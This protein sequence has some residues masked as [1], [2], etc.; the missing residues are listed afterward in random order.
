MGYFQNYFRDF[1]F[2]KGAVKFSMKKYSEAVPLFEK[3]LK[4][5][6]KD[7]RIEWTYSNIGRCYA[8]LGQYDKAYDIL[9]KAYDISVFKA[10]V[11]VKNT[12]MN[13]VFENVGFEYKR[14]VDLGV[15]SYL[16][17]LNSVKSDEDRPD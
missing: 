17:D 13:K 9:S 16:F 4:S 8:A 12:S 3:S 2:M 7:E 14:Y 15:Y 11:L 10:D 6:M 1:Y 5:D